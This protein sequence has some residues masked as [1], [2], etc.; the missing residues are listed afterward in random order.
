MSMGGEEGGDLSLVDVAEMV[1]GD[2]G[3][4][5]E[6]KDEGACAIGDA[7]EEVARE[8]GGLDVAYAGGVDVVAGGYAVDFLLC[9]AAVGA[10]PRD[11]GNEVGI[12]AF[13]MLELERLLESLAVV[14]LM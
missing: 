13:E 2:D 6:K 4:G 8:V 3:V 11:E 10:A 14:G 5:I 7:E 9:H 1:G 12:A